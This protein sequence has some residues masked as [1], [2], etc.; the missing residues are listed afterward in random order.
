M[1]LANGPAQAFWTT[2]RDWPSWGRQG[3][4]PALPRKG[5]LPQGQLLA[6]DHCILPFSPFLGGDIPVF[7]LPMFRQGQFFSS[8]SPISEGIAF[9]IHKIQSV[10]Y[11]C[12]LPP[13][14][15]IFAYLFSSMG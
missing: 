1:K 13:F 15:V 3:K 5:N 12:R 4:T 14:L 2:G 10:G 6:L 9:L 8:Y 11:W 7:G